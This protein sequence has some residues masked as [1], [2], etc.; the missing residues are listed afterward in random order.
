MSKTVSGEAKKAQSEE[1]RLKK[2]ADAA[3]IILENIGEDPTRA[4]LLKE[5]DRWLLLAVFCFFFFFFFF[6]RW[7]GLL[8]TPMRM[9]KAMAFFTQGY[10][11]SLEQVVGRGVF[12][13][14]SKSPD[15]LSLSYV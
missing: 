10:Q 6:D 15:L 4:G 13:E 8:D 12:D 5:I 7:T 2:I 9:A 14:V 3:R 11:M 1:E